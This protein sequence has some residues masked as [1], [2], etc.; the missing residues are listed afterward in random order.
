[1]HVFGKKNPDF[2]FSVFPYFRVLPCMCLWSKVFLSCMHPTVSESGLSES[3]CDH[4]HHHRP[5][6]GGLICLFRVSW[7]IK[8]M[9][10]NIGTC[11]HTRV[12]STLI[13]ALVC[14]G[15]SIFAWF[16]LQEFSC[17]AREVLRCLT[18]SCQQCFSLTSQEKSQ[19][20][21]L[22]PRESFG[23]SNSPLLR[24]WFRIQVKP[25]Q[26][27]NFPEIH[28]S[29]PMHIRIGFERNWANLMPW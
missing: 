28:Y 21:F 16:L 25:S 13:S 5:A 17:K 29:G 19:K 22:L 14:W 2:P 9:A 27:Q 8:L 11:W 1:M 10:W 24:V 3:W 26:P 18:N 12:A 23:K 6:G 4:C 20:K 7:N 15:H